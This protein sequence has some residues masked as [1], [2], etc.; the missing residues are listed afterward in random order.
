MEFE[1]VQK[2]RKPRGFS[3]L[4]LSLKT[5]TSC[6]L[7]YLCFSRFFTFLCRL[8]LDWAEGR[9]RDCALRCLRVSRVHFQDL[10]K[11]DS[12]PRFRSWSVL[13]K[14]SEHD[15]CFDMGHKKWLIFSPNASHIHFIPGF[16]WIKDF[17]G[18][19]MLLIKLIDSSLHS[20][21]F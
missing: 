12:Q 10:E 1:C 8:M 9:E 6:A 20:E 18:N 4:I 5:L 2:N 3:Y 11:K 19:D 17:G 7:L 13:H 15:F 21:T 16:F 14:I